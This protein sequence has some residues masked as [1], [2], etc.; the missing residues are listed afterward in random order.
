[1]N[2][3]NYRYPGPYPFTEAQSD[4]FFGRN[5]E[6]QE[7][8]YMI[9]A[10][11]LVVL[12]AKSGIGKTSLLQ[13]GVTPK[14]RQAN[15][16]PITIRFNDTNKTPLQIFKDTFCE[17]TNQSADN[18]TI[19][20]WELL[21]N[22]N[23]KQGNTTQTPLLILDQFEELFTLNFDAAARLEFFNALS[24]LV[25]GEM[26]D[27]VFEQLAQA[28][29]L[30]DEQIRDYEKAPQLKIVIALRS[31]MLHYLDEISMPIPSILRNR[32]QL[33]ALQQTAAKEAIE[34]PAAAEGEGF[35]IAERF[36]Y[37]PS[38]LQDIMTV[39]SKDNEVESFQLQLVCRG[40]EERIL[41]G[42]RS[43]YDAFHL[44]PTAENGLKYLNSDF[45]GGQEGI[46]AYIENF[47]REVLQKLDTQSEEGQLLIENQLLT[48]SGR[49]RSVDKET[50]LDQGATAHI[51]AHFEQERLLR[52]EPRMKTFYY[53]ISHDTLVEPILKVK[54]ERLER[55]EKERL[56]KERVAAEARA[57]EE[58]RKRKQAE[59]Q[60]RNARLLAIG[61][62]IG[63]FVA[64]LASYFAYVKMKEAEVAKQN[65]EAAVKLANER[66]IDFL[67]E[68]I[69]NK[70]LEI[71]GLE[72]GIEIYKT[73]NE[74]NLIKIN[75]NQISIIQ[76]NIDSL[77]LEIQKI[78]K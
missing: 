6:A 20:L 76:T 42:K 60:R 66:N 7:L 9:A 45:F 62:V 74:V 52:K 57:Q 64:L 68:K 17:K 25:S 38:A 47:Y 54:K 72:K 26:P 1:M 53:E 23:L 24:Y 39:L 65:A 43:K 36:G 16:E 73:S 30:N 21:K 2:E 69:N 58:A 5:R 78:A 56:E 33:L 3:L 37:T 8:F 71:K 41:K 15:I 75:N 11:R 18:Q 77:N 13:A 32:Y 51:L 50:L 59:K 46:L 27:S 28:G 22:T 40:I 55:E 70:Q 35:K 14:L 31:D 19:T 4:L 67:K 34:K 44:T 61:A 63:L 49:R 12:F 48:D 29:K 10:E